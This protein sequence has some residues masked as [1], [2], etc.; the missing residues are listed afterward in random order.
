MH[1][2]ADQLLSYLRAAW[3]YRWHA[4][5]AAWL[6]ALAGW[7][8]VHLMPDRYEANARVYVDT[9]SMLRPL[10]SGI[11]VQ[12]NVDQVVAMMSRT[13]VSRA[14]VEKV[15]QMA[16]IDTGLAS[17]AA[18]ER[19]IAG[20]TK[21][22]TITSGGRENFYTITY[23]NEDPEQARRVVESL[24]TLFVEGSLGDKRNDTV[25]ARQ[26]IEDQLRAY[27]VKLV[28]AENA[29][30]A[31]KRRH[32]GLMPGE[33]R[34][35]YGRLNDARTE[36]RKATL[37]L[38]EALDARDALKQQLAGEAK[39]SARPVDRPV[40]VSPPSE[41]DLRIAALE[42][43]LDNL[44]LQYTEQHPD[45]VASEH[46]IAQLKEQKRAELAKQRAA[47]DSGH[48]STSAAPQ[49]QV[50]EQLTISLAAAEAKVAAMKA[51]VA[52]YEI[53][54][55]EL[56][57]AAR[58]LPQIEAEYKQLTRDY[59]V[60]KARYDKLLER[61]ESAQITGDV[62]MSEVAMG[63]YRVID[64]PRVSFKPSWPNRPKLM[65][66]VLV[67]AL[68]GGFG[69]AFVLSQIRKTFNDEHS[70]RQASGL[71]VLGS[72]AMTW[73]EKQKKRRARGA[74]A[75]VLSFL[76]L[77]SAYGTIMASLMLAASRV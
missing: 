33:G 67:A 60:I 27:S 51:R 56:Q 71:P 53:R 41:L 26:F 38:R 58:A 54:H 75:L 20:L 48:K 3:R 61:R 45:I 34:D 23:A 6:L 15:I 28:V 13:L 64:P 68:A 12:P 9:Q 63:R 65:T 59:E 46:V 74:F 50:Y 32:Q 5:I 43:K 57:A 29:V 31:F 76:G 49:G 1:E 21:D 17:P 19:L 47:V 30:M 36:L 8:A 16:G 10:L 42:Q 77:V 24:L 2:L 40:A 70:L 7:T 52:E 39:L 69:L 44:R 25:S 18:R 11:A 62:E 4:A 72:V 35:Y 14:N 37:E 73:N 55:N 66:A 22:I